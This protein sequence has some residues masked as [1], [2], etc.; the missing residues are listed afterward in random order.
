MKEINITSKFKVFENRT[1]LTS[2]DQMLLE[3]AEEARKNS[4]AP[5]SS[6]NVGASI[7]LENG[8][9]ILGNNQE[10]AAY[11]SG[12]CAERVAIWNAASRFPNEKI[13][14]IFIAASSATHKVDKPVSPCGA[15]RQTIAEYEFK[16]DRN[17]EIFFTGET[18]IIIQAG[19]L[20]DLLPLA[21]DNTLL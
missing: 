3:K 9:I 7:L 1:D 5:Y 6:F 18:G 4:Y 15:C 17:I 2:Q 19:S 11:P 16:Q 20:N 14:K 13:L 10:N 21:F 12:I 8:E